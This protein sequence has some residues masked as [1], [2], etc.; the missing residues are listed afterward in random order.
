MRMKWS[1]LACLGRGSDMNLDADPF[2][3]VRMHLDLG[4]T[5][6]VLLYLRVAH[7]NQDV[8]CD[9]TPRSFLP[10][11]QRVSFTVYGFVPHVPHAP[12]V[13]HVPHVPRQGAGG[14]ARH[15][16]AHDLCPEIDCNLQHLMGHPLCPL[17][18]LN[19]H[20]MP[21]SIVILWSLG[22]FHGCPSA[23]RSTLN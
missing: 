2:S 21:L 5:Y 1:S 7:P 22:V 17:R 3:G 12:H 9:R 8:S 20:R 10:A 11:S 4:C 13:P 23:S 16:L 19:P 18:L 6:G 15:C 14:S